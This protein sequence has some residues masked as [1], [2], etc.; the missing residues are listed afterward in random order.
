M[1]ES[2]GVVNGVPVKNETKLLAGELP[3][4]TV[5]GQKPLGTPAGDLPAKSLLRKKPGTEGI[6]LPGG[7]DERRRKLFDLFSSQG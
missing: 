6:P 7:S 2:A 3:R 4:A 1:Y 5:L